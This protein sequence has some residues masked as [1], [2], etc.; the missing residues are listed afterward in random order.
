MD[1]G[2]IE[3]RVGVD[4]YNNPVSLLK[5]SD[6][7]TYR[8]IHFPHREGEI[9]SR[10]AVFFGPKYVSVSLFSTLYTQENQKIRSTFVTCGPFKITWKDSK[11]SD[12][13]LPNQF[14]SSRLSDVTLMPEDSNRFI[15]FAVHYISVLGLWKMKKKHDHIEA[16]S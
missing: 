9:T 8:M 11:V 13:S 2:Y 1:F 4:T 10:C 7:M 16:H 5:M 14:P 12:Y 15:V 6:G 3:D